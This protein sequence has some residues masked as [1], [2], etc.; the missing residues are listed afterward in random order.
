MFTGL[1]QAIGRIAA[2]E[3]ALLVIDTDGLPLAGVKVGDSIAVSGVCLTA[4]ALDE[5]AFRAEISDA[6]RAATTLGTLAPGARVNLE[7]ALTLADPLGGHL[8]SGHVDGVGG[9]VSVTPA[10]ESRVVRIRVPDELARYVARKG[11]VAV[12]GVSLTVNTVTGSEFEV[13]LIPHTLDQTTLGGLAAGDA[14]NVEVDM[15]ARYLERLI[16]HD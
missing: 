1:V 16:E 7:R 5:R 12:D 6:T 3:G 2:R 9:V 14:V 4:T 8:V 15:L 11:S 13:N 10:G